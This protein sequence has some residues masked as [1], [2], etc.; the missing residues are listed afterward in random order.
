MK[1]TLDLPDDLFR[2]VKSTAASRGIL[3]KQFITEAL[4][5]KLATPYPA[6]VARP[7]MKFAGCMAND[8]EMKAELHRITA[9]VEK[10]FGQVDP[11]DWK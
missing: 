1:T 10:E 8:P 5:E 2:Q 3:M 6:S 11:E 4:I 7:W 9:I